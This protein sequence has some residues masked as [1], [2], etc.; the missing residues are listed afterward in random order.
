M[1]EPAKLLSVTL[2]S[3][4]ILEWS[5]I[6]PE[7][8][9]VNV[10]G[11]GSASGSNGYRVSLQTAILLYD[12]IC[13]S[14]F[15]RIGKTLWLVHP[16]NVAVTVKVV[17]PMPGAATGVMLLMVNGGIAPLPPVN[18]GVAAPELTHVQLM[19]ASLVERK[20]IAGMVAPEQ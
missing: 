11:A 6:V 5:S 9:N 16:P 15:T 1:P 2:H 12:A 20:L 3:K 7:T 14:G 19:A 18:P 4:S 8:G 17:A 13:G 10:K